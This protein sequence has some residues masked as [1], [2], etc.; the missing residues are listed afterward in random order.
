M[1]KPILSSLHQI[2]SVRS[3]I[4]RIGAE[5]RSIRTAVVK[6][7]NGKY[8]DDVA[9]IKFG[10]EGLESINVAEGR[11]PK[12]YEPDEDETKAMVVECGQFTWPEVQHVRRW[13]KD[14]EPPEL[15]QAP[16]DKVF[17]FLDPEG[18]I[19]MKQLRGNELKG[20][21]KYRPYTLWSDGVIRNLEPDG[22]LPLWGLPQLKKYTTAFLHEGAKAARHIAELIGGTLK[23]H[24]EF[25][26]HPWHNELDHAA[27]LGWIGGAQS[28]HRTDWSVLKKAGIQHV[29]IVSDND[30]QGVSAVKKIAKALHCPTFHVQFTSDWPASFDLGDEFPKTMFK[31]IGNRT[32]FIGHAFEECVYP[33]TYATSLGTPKTPKAAPPVFLRDYFLDQ[34]SY[35]DDVALYVW[36][37]RPDFRKTEDDFNK[38]MAAFSDT[39]KLS[40]LFHKAYTGRKIKLTYQPGKPSGIVGGRASIN[41]FTPT[42]IKATP[43]DPAPFLEFME[44]LIPDADDR[45]EV[46]RWAATLIAKPGTRMHY[47]LLLMSEK[48][49]TGKNTF[50]E[51]ILGP[52]VGDLN[53]SV[54]SASHIVKSD[55]NGWI[56]AKRLVVISEIYEGGSW[57]AY[58]KMK[59]FLTDKTVEVNE[60]HQRAYKIE[61]WAHFVACSNSRR[62]LRIEDD[63]R[64]WLIPSIEEARWP[65]EKFGAFYEWLEAGG[66]GII[67]HWAEE[68]ERWS[69]RELGIELRYV[70]T[71]EIAPATTR[72]RE[73]I[74]DSQSD[75]VKTLVS[76]VGGLIEDGA[77]EWAP[78]ERGRV[79]ETPMPDG[80]VLTSKDIRE[81]L[82]SELR[83][84]NDTDYDLGKAIVKLGMTKIKDQIKIDGRMVYVYLSPHAV[85]KHRD[86]MPN[87]RDRPSAEFCGKV[88][89]LRRRP[90]NLMPP[91]GM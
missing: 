10:S 45:K 78:D 54:P 86:L 41:I 67:R 29:Y 58:Q 89:E 71:G 32:H 44:Y 34:W 16:A 43:G 66:L 88:R 36:N 57:I 53:F 83:M 17:T 24:R 18:R 74:V 62:A 14:D 50:A 37:Q 20:E 64:R 47:S 56:E 61:N 75:A 25:E 30:K 15:R 26:D 8:W 60:K 7:T 76:L 46:Y 70:K 28:P 72:K 55:F 63:D 91:R 2:F 84:F 77:T 49:G 5:V 52:L 82:R 9:T 40:Q 87:G 4:E 33:A 80:V 51:H 39:S 69:K 48:Q 68:F 85:E 12:N 27:H 59:H 73:M 65:V 90:E 35:V 11:S 21:P 19:L 42:R 1:T 79:V 38:M 31:E 22:L 3:Y 23:E 13:N 6:E 81:W